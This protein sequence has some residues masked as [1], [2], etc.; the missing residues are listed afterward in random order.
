MPHDPTPND[1]PEDLSHPTTLRAI[2]A[3]DVTHYAVL[4]AH[5]H[6]G[7]FAERELE[8]SCSREALIEDIISGNVHRVM[9]VFAFNPVE[10]TCDDVT[11]SI[12][13]EVANRLDPSDMPPDTVIDFV[14][15]NAGLEYARGLRAAE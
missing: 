12:A 8:A 9:K 15:A 1:Y 4:C 10:H 11:E 6:L 5:Q 7:Y 14:E 13:I 3:R 2:A